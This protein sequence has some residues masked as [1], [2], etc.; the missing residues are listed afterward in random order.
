MESTFML[1]RAYATLE[2]RDV[3]S[4]K[5]VLTGIATTPS[6]DRYGDIIE[7]DGATVSLPIP[8]LWQHDS[9]QPIGQVTAA[10]ARKDGIEVRV[11]LAKVEEPGTL[12]DRLE[13]AWQSIKTGLVRGLSIGF[14]GLEHTYIENSYGIHFLKWEWLELSAVT[15]PANADASITAIKRFDGEVLRALQGNQAQQRAGVRLIH[16]SA[17]GSRKPLSRTAR[18]AVLLNSPGGNKS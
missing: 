13:E 6:T 7:S 4:E 16:P 1:Q 10:K 2:L 8:F 9:M 5:R 12:R 11:D 14:R 17:E 18:G 15:I 3:D